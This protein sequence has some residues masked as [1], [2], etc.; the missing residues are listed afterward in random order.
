MHSLHHSAYNIITWTS[1]GPP[2]SQE[3]IRYA[4]V[5]LKGNVH[6]EKD[7]W[8]RKVGEMSDVDTGTVEIKER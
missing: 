3:G 6:K 5:V 7:G 8:I 2:R 4:L 1:L